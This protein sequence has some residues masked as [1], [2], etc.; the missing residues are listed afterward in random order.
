V[1]PLRGGGKLP[2]LSTVATGTSRQRP[3]AHQ[4]HI[5]APLH[6]RA[7]RDQHVIA[8]FAAASG[9][10]HDARGSGFW[11][12]HRRRGHRRRGHRPQRCRADDRMRG[13]PA[14][15]RI[16]KAAAR[17]VTSAST[18]SAAHHPGEAAVHRARRDS[19]GRGIAQARSTA[20]PTAGRRECDPGVESM[21]PARAT[22]RVGSKAEPRPDSKCDLTPGRRVSCARSVGL[23]SCLRGSA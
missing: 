17:R 9:Q 3:A 12:L 10:E 5:A 21:V 19:R 6:R 22:V 15:R 20:P 18:R 16:T 13:E 2:A 14:A 23:G 7:A 1:P 11:P 4:D 8:G